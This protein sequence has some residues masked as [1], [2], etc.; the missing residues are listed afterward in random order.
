MDEWMDY[1][2]APSPFALH[3]LF[4]NQR[5]T[6]PCLTPSLPQPAPKLRSTSN[7]NSSWKLGRPHCWFLRYMG[8]YTLVIIPFI[9]SARRASSLM[10]KPPDYAASYLTHDDGR[11]KIRFHGVWRLQGGDTAG[12]LQHLKDDT[13]RSLPAPVNSLWQTDSCRWALHF[14]DSFLKSQIVVEHPGIDHN[15]ETS[16]C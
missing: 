6:F 16:L 4:N 11:V 8:T 13:K 5:S 12:S 3:S 1:R 2:S 10:F 15:A 7:L 9:L 14:L